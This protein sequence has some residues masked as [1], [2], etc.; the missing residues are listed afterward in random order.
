M[1]P[2]SLVGVPVLVVVVFDEVVD[3][4]GRLRRVVHDSAGGD[5]LDARG[6]GVVHA[7]ALEEEPQRSGLL[8][9]VDLEAEGVLVADD[10]REAVV[11]LEEGAG[12]L[13]DARA[14]VELAVEVEARQVADLRGQAGDLCRRGQAVVE[15]DLLRV[16]LVLHVARRPGHLEELG[17]V[18]PVDLAVGGDLDGVVVGQ[19]QAEAHVP[20]PGDGLVRLVQA[21]LKGP[22][23]Q[24]PEGP[25]LGLP[26]FRG[27][28]VVQDHTLL[29]VG[30]AETVP[31]LS[32]LD[33]G[34]EADAP[35]VDCGIPED[36]LGPALDV[37][38]APQG[39]GDLDV[40]VEE[41]GPALA[42]LGRV[43]P[44]PH[45][46]QVHAPAQL[47]R[48]Q[49]PSQ[50]IALEGV[51]DACRVVGV[52]EGGPEGQEVGDVRLEAPGHQVGV[53][54]LGDGGDA[55][56]D[57]HH[58]VGGAGE[59]PRGAQAA[60]REVRHDAAEAGLAER[61]RRQ[62]R[63]D[64]VAHGQG[65]AVVACRVGGDDEAVEPSVIARELGDSAAVKGPGLGLA[66]VV[67]QPP[68]GDEV[69]VVVE[70][71]LA[72]V[73]LIHVRQVGL[74]GVVRVRPLAPAVL[75]EELLRQVPPLDRRVE[76]FHEHARPGDAVLGGAPLLLPESVAV[77]E[78][79]ARRD[80]GAGQEEKDEETPAGVVVPDS[81]HGVHPHPSILRS[82][83][84]KICT[85]Y[86]SRRAR[87]YSVYP[88]WALPM[89]T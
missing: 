57:Q 83:S 53:V 11:L 72:L 17:D 47:S 75:P 74:A 46:E 1:E 45:E 19:A 71:I 12:I 42:V 58:R 7:E 73:G 86:S 36:A 40:G 10:A 43:V 9:Q 52:D 62:A 60:G 13:A 28:G 35:A 5:R 44:Q 16:Q 89:R 2:P 26:L 27:Q 37:D 67:D 68:P 78:L 79:G 29:A 88:R 59:E 49:G 39:G 4:L 55:S 6:I 50:G 15:D 24:Q 64:L 30:P 51:A 41:D 85:G 33:G 69:A 3:P 22:L 34:V 48:G 81:I 77:V 56:E 82:R 18:V 63:E 80:R 66:P 8:R 23:Q 31:H 54:A 20:D 14:H 70:E 25:G 32:A 76:G 87:T 65:V 21:E 61:H 38:L 84:S